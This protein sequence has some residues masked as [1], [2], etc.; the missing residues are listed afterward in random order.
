MK[1]SY[2]TL[3]TFFDGALPSPEAIG[4][5][6][7]FHAWEL[8]EIVPMEGDTM[9][10]IKVLPDKSPWALSHRGIAK[11][12]SVILSLPL[13]R[14]PFS[15]L[16][17]LA[18]IL[19]GLVV[20]IETDTCTR[21]TAARIEG[22]K[23]GPSPDW[24][25]SA[26]KTIG[27]RSI[28]NVVDIT[29]YVLFELGQPLHAFDSTKMGG[30]SITVRSAKEGESITTLTGESY[31]LSTDDAVIADG[32][33]GGAIGIAGIKGGKVAEVDENTTA[34]LL[35]S[36][37]FG[38]IPV[39]KSTQRL[40]LR[41]DASV[42]Y[43]NGIV[44]ELT[45]YGLVRAATLIAEIAGGTITGYADTGEVKRTV[46]PVSITL[47]KINSVLGRSF[48][49]EE[50]TDILERFQYSYT[51]GDGVFT[52][53]PPFER[54]D[55]II[56]EDIIEEIGR[57][58]GYADVPSIVPEPIE[59]HELNTRFYYSERI[60]DVL[61][62]V[63]FSEVYT[64]SF[65]EKDAVKLANA[66]AA[67]K[68]YLRSSL[69]EN[70]SEALVKNVPHTDLLGIQSVGLFEIGTVFTKEGESYRVALGV[71]H[72]LEY[73]EKT[74]LPRLT[75]SLAKLEEILGNVGASIE[76][77]IAEFDFGAVLE[78]LPMPTAYAEFEKSK[79]V[80]YTPFSLYP[81]MSR[82]VAFWVNGDTAL[83]EIQNVLKE[84]AGEL[85]VRLSLF[86]EFKKE[87]RTSYG[88]RFVFQSI[89]KTLT[90]SD[91]QPIMER[92]YGLISERGWEAR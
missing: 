75:E 25:K 5:A 88:F 7:T 9:L 67:D 78:K 71:R 85:C 21:Y 44:P 47:R 74:D 20:K 43:E 52:V 83:S 36:A 63:G 80:V 11:D 65:R 64:S 24:I 87:E 82:D 2:N 22:V 17:S 8:E 46:L 53:T 73:K 90:E 38:S 61:T 77:G 57:V 29:N 56:P 48:T 92:I 50:V 49:E 28:N 12:L 72:G 23:I 32:T 54:T 84:V 1:I 68:G 15:E 76:D 62:S 27:Q 14:D 59:Q 42:R 40:K 26:L 10:D 86:D 34:I 45:A 91:V 79:D 60:R 31:V 89:E 70:I 66:F 33:T 35:E 39:R 41:T 18:P 16:P 6:L 58:H 37:H 19:A 69:R 81:S 3:N 4:D 55:L 51:R 30:T 13:V